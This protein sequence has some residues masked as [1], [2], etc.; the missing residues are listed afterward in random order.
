VNLLVSFKYEEYQETQK[1]HH[2]VYILEF[3][4]HNSR[5]VNDIWKRVIDWMEQ[6][7]SYEEIPG[8]TLKLMCNGKPLEKSATSLSEAGIQNNSKIDVILEDETLKEFKEDQV[9]K[10]K[11]ETAVVEV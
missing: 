3:K 6:D 11:E 4:C 8:R 1:I 7:F 2:P 5:E 10:P 9:K